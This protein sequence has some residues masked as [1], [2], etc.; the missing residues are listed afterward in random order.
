MQVLSV[1]YTETPGGLSKHY[2]DCHQILYIC[3][4]TVRATVGGETCL[5][6]SGN[7]LILGRFEEHAIEVLS[8]E[9]RRYTLR[10][11]PENT[12]DRK[13]NDLLASVLTNRTKNF[14]HAVDVGDARPAFDALFAEMTAEYAAQ[15]PLAADMLELWLNRLLILLYRLAPHLFTGE[16]GRNTAVIRAIQRRLEEDFAVEYTLASLAAEY[17]L[18]P[19]HLSHLFKQLTGF[20]PMEYLTARRLSAAKNLLSTTEKSVKEIVYRCGFSDESNFC[21]LFKSRIGLTPLDF[22]KKYPPS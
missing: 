4:G 10:I 16:S 11:S 15:A 22:R 18:S 9:Y 13:E 3:S 12:R 14:H 19:S 2:H 7:L 21:R 1:S 5:V 8:E 6:G 17:H 20:A